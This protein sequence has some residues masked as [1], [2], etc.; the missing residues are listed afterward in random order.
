MV[1][2][3]IKSISTLFRAIG[4]EKPAHN[5][6]TRIFY[7][8]IKEW[9]IPWEVQVLIFVT[10]SQAKKILIFLAFGAPMDI[11]GPVQLD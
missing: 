3:L 2:A 7:D 6:E 9:A 11:G 1:D 8:K 5:G 10:F 4:I